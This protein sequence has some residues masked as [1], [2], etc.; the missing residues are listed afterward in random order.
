MRE[1]KIVFAVESAQKYTYQLQSNRDPL[2][3]GGR[4]SIYNF[5]MK[6]DSALENTREKIS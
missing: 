2:D 3:K 6:K 5:R 4:K 1:R